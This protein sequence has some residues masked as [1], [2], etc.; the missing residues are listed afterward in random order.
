M[1]KYLSWRRGKLIFLLKLSWLRQTTILSQQLYPYE[2]QN[3][4]ANLMLSS[5]NTFSVLLVI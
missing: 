5:E 1:E 3:Y 4:Y 2:K